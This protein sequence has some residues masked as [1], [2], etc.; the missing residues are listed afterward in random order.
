MGDGRIFFKNLRAS[1]FNDDLSNE[2]N[3]GRVHLTGQFFEIRVKY[4]FYVVQGPLFWHGHMNSRVNK[5][6]FSIYMYSICDCQKPLPLFTEHLYITGPRFRGFETKRMDALNYLSILQ[7]DHQILYWIRV[8]HVLGGFTPLF[9]QG[10][11]L[12]SGMQKI[13][14][15]VC[16]V[17]TQ[18]I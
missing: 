9:R 11:Y 2:P 15:S 5:R 13:V 10:N 12:I 3:F 8:K 14:S 16:T 6:Y 1:L 4:P 7:L 17:V 18:P